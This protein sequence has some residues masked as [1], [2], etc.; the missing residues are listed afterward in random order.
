MFY[1]VCYLLACR[2]TM[3]I[4]STH[5]EHYCRTCTTL[6]GRFQQRKHPVPGSTHAVTFIPREERRALPADAKY[7]QRYGVIF[8]ETS[9]EDSAVLA[10]W[11]L[12]A[13]PCVCRLTFRQGHWCFGAARKYCSTNKFT[14]SLL[15]LNTTVGSLHIF[16]YCTSWL[17]LF[18]HLYS[19]FLFLFTIY[20]TYCWL[21][22]LYLRPNRL[23]YTLTCYNRMYNMYFFL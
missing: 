7:R 21:Y 18:V 23:Y 9:A 4:D 17:A 1:I 5:E 19:W 3:A 11:T 14:C 8:E 10:L 12:A 6:Y 13:A 15:Q 20:Y 22:T 2:Y 16:L